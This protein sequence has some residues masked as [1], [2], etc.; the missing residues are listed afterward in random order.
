LSI[1]KLAVSA[2]GYQ[3]LSMN[4]E[5]YHPECT[6]MFS[7]GKT[8][9][10]K[11]Y[12]IG[13]VVIFAAVYSQYFIKLGQVLGF[14]VVY[15]IPVAVISL[16]FGKQLLQN[17]GKN[18]KPAVKFGL[19]LFGALTVVSI[20]V[21]IMALAIILTVDPQA[22]DLL[23]KPNPVLEV[24][25]NVAWIMIAV[26]FLVVGPAEEYLFRG[27]MY[28]GLIN[29]SKGKHW[30]LIAIVSSLLFASVH[31][32]YAVTYGIASV[33][34]FISLATFSIAMSIT[35]YWTGGNL[36]VLA[37]IHGAYD[38]TGFLGVATANTNIGLAARSVL[39]V[40][41]IAFAVAYLPKKIHL[42]SPAPQPLPPSGTSPAKGTIICRYC[43]TA[44]ALSDKFCAKCGSPLWLDEPKTQ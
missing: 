16:I 14:L 43:G 42:V 19:G 15:G 34:P 29:I 35:F 25:P 30:L 36:L 40:V 20:I 32:Y 3:L 6:S 5:T 8:L 10:K 31:A 23:A 4:Q 2:V 22:A 24:S 18:N 7:T 27:F 41:G 13:I 28:G 39:I 12:I 33:V 1:V 11:L 37:L 26:S 17:A 38:A 44:G 21:S 9:P